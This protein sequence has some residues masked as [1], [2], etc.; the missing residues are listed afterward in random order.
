[1]DIFKEL[2][3]QPI[4]NL[5]ILML[6]LIKDVG[7]VVILFSVFI[8]LIFWP[9]TAKTVHSQKK[10]QDLQ[11]ELEKV[12]AQAAG[13]KQKES[14]LMME[15]YK[16]KGVNP[17][18]SCLPLLIQLPFMFAIFIVFNNLKIDS[19]LIYDWVKNLD[20][21][22]PLLLADAFK[23]T[24]LGLLDLSRVPLKNGFYLSGAL[25]AVFMGLTQYVQTK[26]LQPEKPDK[27]QAFMGQINLLFPAM[28]TYFSF[29]SFPLIL[30]LYWTVYNL[31]NIL[32][33]RLILKEDAA[34]LKALSW[35]KKPHKERSES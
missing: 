26:M 4:Y 25:L 28:L 21:I 16:E 8:R 30:T 20:F 1:M 33:Q 32:Q 18:S 19:E 31:M 10:M 29:V 23:P 7:L 5:I 9:L 34:I 3:T 15:L 35:K 14:R 2:F 12:K 22:K 17:F 11:P 24:L 27:T 6:G 13:D